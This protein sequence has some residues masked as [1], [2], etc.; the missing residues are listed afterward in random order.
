[1]DPLLIVIIVLAVLVVLLAI[2][3]S[4]ANRRRT[5]AEAPALQARIQEANEHLARA[6]AQDKGW[7]RAT[8]EGAARDAYRARHGRDP[9]ALHLVQVVDKPGIEEDEAVFHADGERIVLGRSGDSWVA[10]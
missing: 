3:G 7:E 9:Q 10:R 5:E 2:G 1:M 4:V 6:H 8:V